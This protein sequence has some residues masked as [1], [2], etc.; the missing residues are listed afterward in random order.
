MRTLLLLLLF[1]SLLSAQAPPFALRIDQLAAPLEMLTAADR[2]VVDEA[3]GLI[4][5][6]QHRTALDRLTELTKS[7]PENSSLHILAAYALLQAGNIVSAIQE[8]TIAHDA[9]N[10]GSYKCAFRAKVALMNGDTASCK[11]ELGHL[12]KVGDQPAEVRQIEK[13]LKAAKSRR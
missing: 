12:R 6:G 7:H 1:V 2:K 11:E 4:R 8:A 5:D 3:M 10:G 13:D 9:P